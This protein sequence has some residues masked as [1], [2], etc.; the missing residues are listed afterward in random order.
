ML[1]PVDVQDLYRA[2]LLLLLFPKH[3][4][5]GLSMLPRQHTLL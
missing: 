5:T 2:L 1:S 4:V 3:A